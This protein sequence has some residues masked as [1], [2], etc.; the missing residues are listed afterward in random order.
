MIRLCISTQTPPIRPLAA[1]P[2]RAGALWQ[3]GRDYVPQ[4]GG[5]VP[6]M[7]ALLREGRSA[8]IAPNPRW[9]A[10]G[11]SGVP[12]EI[13]TSEGYTV[14]TLDILP[15]QK[16]LYGR[17][18]ESVWRSFHGPGFPEFVP[19]EYRA[20]VAYSYA[21]ADRL[22]R[23]LGQYDLFYINDFQQI[24]CGVLIGSAA[25]ALLRWHIPIEFRGYPEPVRR[26]FLKMMEG[27]DAIVVSTR[28]GLE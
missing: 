20:F 18:K 8:W 1:P 17:F 23:H 16:E 28:S 13:R 3:L 25:P 21:T 4:V 24:L 26:F 9:V 7:R 2:K 14:E 15:E 22:L 27:Y 5:V 19:E 6:M 11:A 12:G 10:M